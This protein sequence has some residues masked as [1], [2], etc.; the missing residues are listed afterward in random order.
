MTN[1]LIRAFV[2][3]YKNTRSEKVRMRY[4]VLSGVVG[5]VLNIILSV[6]K[7]IFGRLTGSISITVDGANNFFDAGSSI[8]SLAGFKISGKPADREHP[9]GY[10]RIEY[11][12]ALTLAFL[13]VVMGI[14]L[15]K[16]SVAKFSDPQPVTFSYPAVIV[17]VFS[18][19]A[20]IW[21][22]YFNTKVGKSINSIAVNAVVKDSLGDIA[23]T[24]A[25]LIALV[26]SRYTALPIDAVMGIIVALFVLYAGIGIVRE[27]LSPLLGEPP[28]ARLVEELEKLVL[29]HEGVLGIH[30]LVVHSY[31]NSRVFAALHAEVAA[32]VD[33]VVS[34]DMID[35][36]EKE[37]SEKLG[38]ELTIHLD[39][40]DTDDERI[41]KY[42]K[43]AIAIIHEIDS[44]LTLHD[45]RIVDGPTH[46]NLIFDVV[47]PHKFH[48][49]NEELHE[50]FSKRLT[51]IHPNFF[52][53]ISVD[54][55]YVG[56]KK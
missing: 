37:A 6:F 40:I 11:I 16:S 13:I 48:I 22:A 55:C 44:R 45:F 10:G 2:K 3:D 1:L 43:E 32:N 47:V 23:A 25:S 35:I 4:G 56:S 15:I 9:F 7:I 33:V 51:A 26:A 34:H 14:E 38:I 39:P 12:S 46:T 8:V 17:L 18:I 42:K 20:K 53:V 5:I 30:D 24:T 54:K 36:I 41:S 28:E 50:E 49:N 21:L 19:A 52:A 27:T 31:G 29:S